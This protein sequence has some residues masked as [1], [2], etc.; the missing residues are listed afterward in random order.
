MSNVLFVLDCIRCY[1]MVYQ[2]KKLKT[3]VVQKKKKK[4]QIFDSLKLKTMSLIF[5]FFCNLAFFCAFL[6]CC[7]L[8]VSFKM[9][10]QLF[11]YSYSKSLFDIFIITDSLWYFDFGRQKKKY[12]NFLTT[13][14]VC[15][16]AFLHKKILIFL[17]NLN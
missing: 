15:N 4:F 17:L 1:S 7:Y 14:I 12:F 16:K 6:H 3:K 8:S 9:V 10:F 2:K 13:L 11:I 5:F